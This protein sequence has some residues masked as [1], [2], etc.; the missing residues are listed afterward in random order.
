MT[1]PG[2]GGGGGNDGVLARSGSGQDFTNG[3]PTDVNGGD[4]PKNS[5]KSRRW[6]C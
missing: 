1:T 6:I 5:K 3:S 2:A 4:P